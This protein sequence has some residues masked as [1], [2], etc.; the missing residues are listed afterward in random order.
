MTSLSLYLFNKREER[1]KD[2]SR[3]LFS[4]NNINTL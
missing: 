4:Y 3:F 2:R 1:E